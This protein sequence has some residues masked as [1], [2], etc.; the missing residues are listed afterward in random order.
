MVDPADNPLR[1]RDLRIAFRAVLPEH[2]APAIASAVEEAEESLAQLV[3]RPGPRSYADTVQ[4]LDDLLE[5]VGRVYGYAYHLTTVRSSPELRAAFAQAQPLYQRFQAQVGTHQG[6][7]RTLR[8]Y[9]ESP[10]AAALDPLRAR[11]LDKTLRAMRRQGADLGPAERHRV[12]SLRV[13]LAR[14]QTTFS[15][16]V[17]DA[18]NAYSY[19][20]TDEEELAGLPPAAIRAARERAAEKG[21]AGWRFTLHAPSLMAVMTHAAHRPL[22]RALA[23]AHEWRA[24][25]GEHD[26]RPL[27]REI[28]ALRRQLAHALGYATYAHYVLE[29]R[30][31]EDVAPARD[32]IETLEARTRPYF[33][34]E[35]ADLRAFARDRLGLD[36]LESWDLRFAF[37]A[38]RRERYRLDEEEL[39]PYFAL[40]EVEQGMFELARRLFGL[41]VARVEAPERWHDDV[42]CFEVRD[43][44]DVLVGVFY[45]DWYP[46]EDKRGGAWMNAL[47]NGGPRPD[48]GFD[49]H[50]GLMC[51]NLTP[52]SDG[53]PALLSLDEVQTLFHEFGHLLH[54]LCTRV[55]VRARGNFATAWDFVELPSQIMENWTYE[56]DALRLFARHVSTGEPIPVELVERVRAARHFQEAWAQMRQLSLAAVDLAMHVDFDPESGD[57]AVAFAQR[58]TE[59]FQVEPRFAHT[60]FL[61]AFTHVFSGGYAAGYYSYK[62]AEVLDADAFGRFAQ[63]GLFDR[64]VG[65]QFVTAIL[66]RGDAADA[67]ELFRDFMGRDP[68]V[69]ALI[70]RNLGPEPAGIAAD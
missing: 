4:A 24:A 12:E 34:R 38:L 15:E 28:L 51:G 59:R 68:D 36:P 8:D 23:T 16:N 17:L 19:L 61:C 27:V 11:H 31:V 10:E 9:A 2:V 5:R 35:I 33:E 39:R 21:Q 44:A 3:A 58:A 66:A 52:G 49:P 13:Q 29:E 20:V 60:G 56:H 7:W 55:E 54:L 45:A 50:V 69:E 41:S 65:R 48:G 62:W 47:V 57:D 26:N 40:S 63:S 1:S 25:A 67:I 30:M 18:T 64:D 43:E 70:R 37:E 53:A 46:R 42:T 22:R 32:F 14:A 6:L